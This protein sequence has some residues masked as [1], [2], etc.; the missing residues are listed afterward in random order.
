MARAATDVPCLASLAKM[1]PSSR[2]FAQKRRM[3]GTFSRVASR[4]AVVFRR[5]AGASG[6]GAQMHRLVTSD[7]SVSLVAC[8]L[9]AARSS[10]GGTSYEQQIGTWPRE[11][12]TRTGRLLS[13]NLGLRYSALP[14]TV[15]NFG[16]G[17]HLKAVVIE[18]LTLGYVLVLSQARVH[19]G[20][21]TSGVRR[22][23]NHSFGHR[24]CLS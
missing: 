3:S 15:K 14:T 21:L 24:S 1:E 2:R 13:G 20:V 22:F 18:P 17:R 7:H 12:I 9:P 6:L 8:H 23:A 19:F 5:C 11:Q 10:V 16:T 4:L